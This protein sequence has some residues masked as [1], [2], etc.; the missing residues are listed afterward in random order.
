MIPLRNSIVNGDCVDIL[1]QVGTGSADFIL[2][3]PP[4]VTR[5]KDRRGRSIRN[6]G[7]FAWINPAF[8]E[9]YRALAPD[10]FCVSFYAWANA[11]KFVSAYH[12]AGFHIAGH[13]VFPKHYT[14][15]KGRV[16]YRHE[17]AY[18]LVKGRPPE[19]PSLIGDV[20][21]WRTYTHNRLHPSQKPLGILTPLIEAFSDPGD[22]VLDPFAGSGSTCVAARR[23]G[24]DFIGIELDADYHAIATE[25]LAQDRGRP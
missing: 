4:Y 24:R 1:R 12:A 22:V 23:A 3:D 25:R 19:R 2:T 15:G 18:L 17:A 8:A 21:P 20:I 9:M 7:N 16:C 13:F 10:S 14:S 6:D 5:Y 11:H